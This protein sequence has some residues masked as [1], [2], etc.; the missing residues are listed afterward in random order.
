MDYYNESSMAVMPYSQEAEQSVLGAIL[1]DAQRIN[2]IM[3][4]LPSAE[5][6]YGLNN[7]MI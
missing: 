4:I 2:E 7:K 3:E 6:F 5:F 1:L